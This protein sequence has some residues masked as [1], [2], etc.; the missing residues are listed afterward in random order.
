MAARFVQR[1]PEQVTGLTLWAAY[2]GR[3]TDL[4]NSQVTVASVYGTVDGITTQDEIEQSLALLPP[5]L[6]LVPIEGGN[7]AQFGWYGPQDGDNPATIPR[8]EQQ[9]IAVQTAL[10][11]LRQ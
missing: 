5:S 6:A 8:R 4:S 7:H 2:P 1:Y 11:Q 3:N 9:A 10:D